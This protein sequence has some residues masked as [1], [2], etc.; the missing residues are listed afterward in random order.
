MPSKN[1]GI[2]TIGSDAE[3]YENRLFLQK[4]TKVIPHDN[5]FSTV[6]LSPACT[7]P[8]IQRTLDGDTTHLCIRG[9]LVD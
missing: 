2:G 1:K 4:K 6:I 5:S 8:V 7:L 3:V 9:I